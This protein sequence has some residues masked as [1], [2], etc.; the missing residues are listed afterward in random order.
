M[1]KNF[2][3]KWFS[4]SGISHEGEVMTWIC[5]MTKKQTGGKN[6]L[7]VSGWLK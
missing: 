3:T 5:S 4:V 6:A 2:K 1:P 7:L